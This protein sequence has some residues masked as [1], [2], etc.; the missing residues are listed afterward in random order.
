MTEPGQREISGKKDGAA[1]MLGHPLILGAI[2]RGVSRHY[3]A[4]PGLAGLMVMRMI[5][6]VVRF[7]RR[8]V[9]QRVMDVFVRGRPA[10]ALR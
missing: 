1:A 3:P 6:R 4:L 9:M 7:C 10:K 8:P 5:G 2:G